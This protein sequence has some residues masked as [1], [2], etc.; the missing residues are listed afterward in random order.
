MG[1][2][3]TTW[4]QPHS[5]TL[6][7]AELA[8]Q[9]ITR[10]AMEGELAVAYIIFF[11]LWHEKKHEAPRQDNRYPAL[12]LNRVPPEYRCVKSRCQTRSFNLFEYENH[13]SVRVYKWQCSEE[14]KWNSCV[15]VHTDGGQCLTS[16][17]AI[18]EKSAIRPGDDE[19]WNIHKN[20]HIQKTKLVISGHFEPVSCDI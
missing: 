3:R 4:H 12:D 18:A 13:V 17:G 2:W 10:A 1:K 8:K 16:V 20:L 5:Q 11:L 15:T 6:F 9:F 7:R 14:C 19:W